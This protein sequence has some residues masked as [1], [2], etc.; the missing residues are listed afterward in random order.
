VVSLAAARGACM[1]QAARNRPG[2]MFAVTGLPADRVTEI[3]DTLRADGTVTAGAINAP[4]QMTI[5][6]DS[7]LTE[8]AAAILKAQPRA[9]VTQLQVKGAWHSEHMR[10]AVLAFKAALDLLALAPPVIP[11]VFNRH[12][13]A[14][15]DPDQI[16]ELLAGQLVSP[17]RWDQVMRSLTELE[18]TDYVEIGPGRVL[19]GLV[20][21]NCTD[22]A[23]RVH[24]VS[25]LRSCD[26]AIEALRDRR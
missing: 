6:G 3:L 16:R 26:R 1:A 10:P 18:V 25:D 20:R 7:E 14:C 12:G 24:N 21:L 15:G 5:S 13:R 11:M 2:S 23:V 8:R 4:R 17:V 9:K 19:R 22:L